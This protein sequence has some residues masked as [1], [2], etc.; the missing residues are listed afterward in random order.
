M[1]LVGDGGGEGDGAT[2]SSS[3]P[4]G[5]VAEGRFR[6]GGGLARLLLSKLS[7][8]VRLRNRSGSARCPR[9]SPP[10]AQK[11]TSEE[12]G[13]RSRKS[14]RIGAKLGTAGDE[15]RRRRLTLLLSRN[16]S[17]V[18]IGVAGLAAASWAAG[19]VGE[20]ASESVTM[21]SGERSILRIERRGEAVERKAN[22]PPKFRPRRFSILEL[23]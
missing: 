3:V 14:Q 10:F 12:C 11:K 13:A 7:F 5:L 4:L 22:N 20:A 8:L 6:R 18:V 19:A 16:P 21:T 1:E 2:R 15:T 9:V 17:E 23:P